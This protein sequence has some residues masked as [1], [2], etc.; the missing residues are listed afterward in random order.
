MSRVREKTVSIQTAVNPIVRKVIDP[1]IV[2]DFYR[3]SIIPITKEGEV[4][5]LLNRREDY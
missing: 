3:N 1:D 5:Y 2:V 4:L